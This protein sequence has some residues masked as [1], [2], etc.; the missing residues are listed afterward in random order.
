VNGPAEAVRFATV[1]I[2]SMY[3]ISV[4]NG[5]NATVITNETNVKSGGS[6][7]NQKSGR[8]FASIASVDEATTRI[9]GREMTNST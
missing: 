5:A 1:A 6:P 4:T 2:R 9:V 8:R 3:A 7:N